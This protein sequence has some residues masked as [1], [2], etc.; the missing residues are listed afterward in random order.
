M[1]T[2]AKC[3]AHNNDQSYR[4][5]WCSCER[6][7]PTMFDHRLLSNAFDMSI[8]KRFMR[9]RFGIT[10]LFTI[11]LVFHRPLVHR[12]FDWANK[13]FCCLRPNARWIHIMRGGIRTASQKKIKEDWD[14]ERE[15]ERKIYG[16]IKITAVYRVV[17]DKPCAGGV[18]KRIC[19]ARATK[20]KIMG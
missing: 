4:H 18:Q 1:W 20:K 5:E 7:K 10:F 19:D 15:R 17:D 11:G 13:S 12:I 16:H 3:A 6:G 8:N 9:L 14:R 2:V